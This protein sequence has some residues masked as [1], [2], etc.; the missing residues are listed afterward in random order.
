MSSIGG[1]VSWS[2]IGCNGSRPNGSR[3]SPGSGII[4]GTGSS[5]QPWHSPVTSGSSGGEVKG[6]SSSPGKCGRGG[7]SIRM[8]AISIM[9]F[10]SLNEGKGDSM[11]AL[12]WPRW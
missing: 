8:S 4:L 9:A 11:A 6:W 7:W 12:V 10:S 1:E 5:V 3:R 2:S